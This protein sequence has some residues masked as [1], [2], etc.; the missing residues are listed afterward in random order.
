MIRTSTTS[1]RTMSTHTHVAETYSA[2]TQK[3]FRKRLKD[4]HARFA[5]QLRGEAELVQKHGGGAKDVYEVYGDRE[6]RAFE[7]DSCEGLR[8]GEVQQI[9]LREVR[10][11][12]LEPVGKAI[13]QLRKDVDRPLRVLEVGCGNATNLMLLNQRFPGVAFS[14]IDIAEGRIAEGRKYWGERLTSVELAQASA[15]DLSLFADKSFDL[16]Y[17]VCAL[18]QIPY[19]LGDAVREM[20]R[21]ADRRIVC[22]EPVFEFGNEAQRLY[23]VVSDQVRT[24]LPELVRQCTTVERHGLLPTLHNPLNPVGLLVATP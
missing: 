8:G 21:L 1:L 22:V 16:V 24:L 15:T 2:K 10:D 14:G 9:S 17:S 11:A 19:S 6:M 12:Y 20:V 13:E 23:N 3:F 18:E 7:T 4:L 5:S